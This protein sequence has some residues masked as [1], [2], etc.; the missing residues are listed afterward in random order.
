MRATA[1]VGRTAAS[2]FA[3]WT[4]TWR[5]Q[6]TSSATLGDAC[7]RHISYVETACPCVV[8]SFVDCV[9]GGSGAERTSTIASTSV[10]S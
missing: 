4:V 8:R 3:S 1:L 5:H 10:T 9:S 6:P 2:S 7:S